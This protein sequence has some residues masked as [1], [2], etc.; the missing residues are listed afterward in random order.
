MAPWPRN[1]A[2]SGSITWPWMSAFVLV[3]RVVWNL[4][5]LEWVTLSRARV[6]IIVPETTLKYWM[7]RIGKVYTL[8]A[9]NGSICLN[10]LQHWT[11]PWPHDL[12]SYPLPW[13]TERLLDTV[14]LHQTTLS[15]PM[16]FK[17]SGLEHMFSTSWQPLV[18]GSAT[19]LKNMNVT[20]DDEIP[21]ISGKIQT[22]ATKPPTR[23]T[24][25]VHDLKQ[26]HRLG[27]SPPKPCRHAGTLHK[28]FKQISN[29]TTNHLNYS[30]KNISCII[31]IYIYI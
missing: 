13:W 2:V 30:E 19:P 18:G 28:I 15:K 6:I 4:W 11:L 22:M 29:S 12:F 25:V 21:N 5:I 10:Q 14:I 31:H 24:L 27:A 16:V 8:R 17:L 20:W 3:E 9:T 26:Q 23:P 1:T 7:A